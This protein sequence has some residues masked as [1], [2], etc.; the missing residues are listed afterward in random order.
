L[1]A[2]LYEENTSLC[3]SHFFAPQGHWLSRSKVLASAAKF[4]AELW[5]YVEP[6]EYLFEEF[7]QS[8]S[9]AASSN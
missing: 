4:S 9:L 1:F 3:A 8:R 5:M 7:F 2:E 6:H